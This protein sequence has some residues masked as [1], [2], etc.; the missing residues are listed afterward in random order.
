MVEIIDMKKTIYTILGAALVLAT[1]ASCNK[2]EELSRLQSEE[3]FPMVEVDFNAD[4]PDCE[5][6][7]TK[8]A[9]TET[10][11]GVHQIT[12]AP[13][14]QFSVFGKITAATKEPS[15]VGTFINFS[16]N[17]FTLKGGTKKT[18][19]G[20]VPD[21]A[22]M[23]GGSSSGVVMSEYCIHPAVTVGN[24]DG[25]YVAPSGMELPTTQD[26]TGWRYCYFF[27]RTASLSALYMN[28]SPNASP[29]KFSLGN[30]LLRMKLNSEKN[31]TKIELSTSDAPVLVGTVEKLR[32][33]DD[34]FWISNGC[35]QKK[36]T[37]VNGGVLPNDVYLA[38]RELRKDKTYT[39]TFTAE[40]GT[41][42]VKSFSPDATKE[43]KVL[44]FG[45]IDLDAWK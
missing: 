19:S 33:N 5:T 35:G 2:A 43:K 26:G 31:V 30:L 42:I 15:L 4:S 44:N 39:L 36:L 29:I 1:L 7:T 41:T 23:Y 21:L 14:D 20:F 10:S 16:S 34:S 9:E 17:R 38:I 37:I 3:Q 11:E 45:T 28:P 40:D 27:S 22:T 24:Y 18:F 13:G 8:I 12:W 25:T 6:P 32:L